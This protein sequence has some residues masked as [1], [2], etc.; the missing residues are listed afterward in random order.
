MT[1]SQD[2]GSVSHFQEEQLPDETRK[3][4][5]FELYLVALILYPSYSSISDPLKPKKLPFLLQ[6]EFL[7]DRKFR[8]SFT[9][10]HPAQSWISDGKWR[11]R[12]PNVHLTKKT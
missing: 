1:G 9:T 4:V 12:V 6:C 2:K 7:K 5:R 3:Q 8:F 10:Q 11:F